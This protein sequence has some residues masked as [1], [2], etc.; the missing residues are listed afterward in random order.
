MVRK[1]SSGR[2]HFRFDRPT[3]EPVY[4]VG[5]FNT[6]DERSHPMRRDRTGGW[7]LVLT[8]GAGRYAYKYYCRGDW[9]NDPEAETY[10]PNAWGSSHSA[11]VVDPLAGG[12]ARRPAQ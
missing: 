6:W 2:V 4:L 9:F 3:A 12:A 10:E 11:V 1:D 7:S 5:D 8:L